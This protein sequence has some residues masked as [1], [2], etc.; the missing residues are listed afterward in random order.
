[1]RDVYCYAY[2]V[3]VALIGF[4][5]LCGEEKKLE[6]VTM[7]SSSTLCTKEVLMTFFPQP[8][9]KEVLL[10]QH[11]SADQAESIAKELAS[12][13]NSEIIKL[14]EEKA[15]RMD[16]NPFKDLNQRDTAV[17][18]FRETLYDVFASVLQKYGMTDEKKVHALLDAIQEAKGKLF[19]ECIRK[20]NPKVEKSKDGL[21][22]AK[23]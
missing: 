7:G 20:E 13:K 19:V 23:S 6:E 18:I 3:L 1:M 16:P 9:V 17:K 14:V 21:K 12:K 22:E 2:S 15:S 8:V 4:N 5:G 11:I 10:Q